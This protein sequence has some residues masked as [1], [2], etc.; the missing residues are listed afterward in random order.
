MRY[1]FMNKNTLILECEIEENGDF[2]NIYDEYNLKYLPFGLNKNNFR[3]ENEVSKWMKGRTIPANRKNYYH[4]LETLNIRSTRELPVNSLWLS[5]SDQYWFK[6]KDSKVE[7]KDVNFF[8]NEFSDDVGKIIVG[9]NVDNPDL[10]SPNNTSDGYLPKKWIIKNGERLLLKG[11]EL[12]NFQEPYN[13]VIASE[14]AKRLDM[15]YVE[16]K[17]VTDDNVVYSACKNMINTNEEIIPAMYLIESEKRANDVSPYNH[18][19]GLCEKYGIKNSREELEDMIILDY[20]M[21]NEDRHQRNY[22]VI[23]NVETL[24]FE[25]VAPIFDT[26]F[27]LLYNRNTESI[28]PYNLGIKPKGFTSTF[29]KSLELIEGWD[30]YDFSK[31]NDI[32]EMMREVLNNQLPTS[33]ID[34]LI[35]VIQNRVEDLVY[36]QEKSL[37]VSMGVK[38]SLV[39]ELKDI[40]NSIEQRN[41][42]KSNKA[43]QKSDERDLWKKD[44]DIRTL[45]KH[46]QVSINGFLEAKNSGDDILEAMYWGEIYGSIN[47]AE[48]DREITPELAWK[49]REKYLGMI[50]DC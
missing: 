18:Y 9:G 42:K 19:L 41:D 40:E 44:I 3:L 20:I 43:I 15:N 11:G 7:W 2:L 46:L 48:T 36:E 1:I 34:K 26:G 14:L 5:L 16:Y 35:T 32:P 22:G 21:V 45:P 39:S 50:K 29:A 12:P 4:I 30:R 31:L 27:S 47:S 24:E 37:N 49:L 8:E 25:R 10:F 6:P 38:K 23:R 33:R 28:N 13:E 17:I